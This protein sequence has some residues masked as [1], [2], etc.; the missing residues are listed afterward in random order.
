MTNRFFSNRIPFFGTVAMLVLCIVCFLLPFALRGARMAMTDMQNNV[1]DWLP[2]DYPE[3]VDLKEFR[4]YFVGDQFVMVT[5]PWCRE[6]DPNYVALLRKLRSESVENDDVL[7]E[8]GLEEELRAHRKGNELGLIPPNGGNYHQDWG[9]HNEKWLQGANQQWY[10][11]NRQGDLYRWEGQNNVVEGAKRAAERL[12][13][14]HN[15]AVGTYIATFGQPPDDENDI[16][17]LFYAFPEKL[18][19]RPF[20]SVTTG[21]EIL[22]MMAG[23]GGTIRIG[24]S[25]DE[26]DPDDL[27]AFQARMEA[28]KRLTGS[29]FGPTPP[30]SFSWTFESLLQSVDED[31]RNRLQSDPKYRRD[32]QDFLQSEIETSY[33]G[34]FNG[35]VNATQDDKLELW[36]RLWE[37]ALGIEA[38]ARQTCLIVT[39]NDPVIGEMARAIGNQHV[40]KARGRLL[41]LATGQCGIKAENVHVGG[42][43]ADSVAIDEEGTNTLFRLVG[44]SLMIG[45][46]LSYASFRSIRVTGMLFF[47]GGTAA[48]AS[49]SY[50]WYAGSRMDAILMSMPSLVYV[51]G[52]SGAV[53][54]VNYYR[55]A[56]YENGVDGAVET[57]FKHGWFPCTLASFTTALG[58]VSLCTSSLTPINKFGFF[59]AIAVMATVLLLF[60]Y[61]PAALTIWPAGYDKR[62]R[63]ET[64][65]DRGLTAAVNKFWEGVCEFVLKNGVAVAIACALAM[66]FFFYG[67]THIRTSVHLLK[68]FDSDAK[69]LQDYR[70][71]EEEVGKL[72]PAE[73]VLNFEKQAQREVCRNEI[74]EQARLEAEAAGIEFEIPEFRNNPNDEL[75]YM[76]VERLELSNRVR[77][78]LEF[79]FGPDGLDI[80]GAGMSTDVFVPMQ[81]VESQLYYPNKLNDRR[82]FFNSQL[83]KNYEGMMAEEYLARVTSA[84]A[85]DPATVGREMWRISLRLAA[86]NDVD[87]GE[88]INDLKAVVEPVMTAYRYRTDI[89]RA[90]QAVQEEKRAEAG[91]DGDITE[92]RILVLGGDPG[93]GT[94]R[95]QATGDGDIDQTLARQVD[96][97]FIFADTL[98]DLLENRSFAPRGHRDPP[99]KGRIYDW[100]D[101][102]D[103]N[104]ETPFPDQEMWTRYLEAFDVIVLIEDHELFDLDFISST[105]DRFVDC[106]DH[107]FEIGARGP[108][109]GEFTA[110]QIHDSGSQQDVT[111]VYTGIVPIVYKSQNQLLVSLIESIA[112]AFCMISVVMMILLRDWN[113]KFKFSNAL[114]IRG[115]LISMFPNLFPILLVF[116]ILGLMGRKVDIGSMMTAS[117]AMG[118]AVDDTIHFLNWY[119]K[120]LSEGMV[121]VDAIRNAYKR[122]ATA[123][124]QTTLIGGLGLAAFALSTFTPTQNFGVLMFFLLASAL[125]GDLIF[126]PAILASPLGKY[127]GRELTD[128]ERAARL[129]VAAD[130]GAALRVISDEPAQVETDVHPDSFKHLE[131]P[132]TDDSREA[133]GGN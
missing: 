111:A 25:E 125:I 51:L 54:I 72:V 82:K 131:K 44:L 39:L 93:N 91:P 101:P 102:A 62:E 127:F 12:V 126:L 35:L 83:E 61:L 13:N 106:R 32:F 121:R 124:T 37:E 10:W 15:E 27:A 107:T 87:Y 98:K 85:S 89:L 75:Q 129:A 2:D 49:L 74:I 69:I 17:N 133:S 33:D 20:K 110:K 113:S 65:S 100:T 46:F 6:G 38:P 78:H 47:V 123:M 130:P 86:L 24:R 84:T 52:L 80:V 81:Q 94:A 57:A 108:V 103:F 132:G 8:M 19:A 16:P 55:D 22:E 117:V 59:A 14:G 31:R 1:A 9:Q 128:S 68:L 112:L 28:N 60:S 53:H 3:T 116:G 77:R 76:L 79:F 71:I 11:I 109:E 30:T 42:P 58:L 36:F 90:T 118:V 97:T 21:P 92:P 18:C 99:T 88:F 70:W 73:I 26:D 29:L 45:V 96:Q 5:G 115:G 105:A 7:K 63:E 120:G 66:C 34:E 50:V 48:I 104:D 122:V 56:C 119:R 43:P 95:I 114:N 64:A 67:V 40:F 23:P 41:E 4:N